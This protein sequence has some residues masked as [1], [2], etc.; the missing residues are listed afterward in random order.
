LLRVALPVPLADAFDYIWAGTGPRPAPGT[1]VEVPFGRG[2]RIGIVVDWPAGTD[3]PPEKPKAA[4][5]A[6]DD[7]PPPGPELLETLRWPADYYHHP[8]GEVLQHALPGLL[9]KG[10][11]VAARDERRFALTEAGRAQDLAA[12]RTRAARQAAALA[13]LAAG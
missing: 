2:R 8:I 11:P 4:A 6:L 3:L 1:R 7:E 5:L 12:L 10:P 9:R 13:R